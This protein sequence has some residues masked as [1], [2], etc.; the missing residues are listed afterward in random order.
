M[1]PERGDQMKWLFDRLSR[2]RR[3]KAEE[4]A[5]RTAAANKATVQKICDDAGVVTATQKRMRR[6]LTAFVFQGLFKRP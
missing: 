2:R 1:P 4:R 6:E 5:A 3:R